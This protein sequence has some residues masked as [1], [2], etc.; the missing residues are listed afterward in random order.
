MAAE[1][2]TARLVG[3]PL[4]TADEP[5][6]RRLFQDPQVAA[7]LGGVRS[8]EE[9]AASCREVEAHWRAHGFGLFVFCDRVTDEP[10]AR[11]GLRR[12]TIVTGDEV[13]VGWSVLPERW[14]EGLATELAEASVEFARAVGLDELV[15]YTT[16]DNAASRRVMEKVG[17]VYER[18]FQHADLPHVLYRRR[19][20]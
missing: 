11:G 20:R 3:R 7:T 15:S 1:I 14:G 19:L 16:V 13:E 4:T 10:L 2:V 6:V 17:F 9:C 18:D 5:F 8:D 12:V